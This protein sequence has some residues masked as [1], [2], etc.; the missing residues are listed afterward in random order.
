[1]YAGVRAAG[2]SG[3][4]PTWYR[5]GYGWPYGTKAIPDSVRKVEIRKGSGVD[6][7]RLAR[8]TCGD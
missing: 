6:R 2:G 3:V 5:W 4:F 1:M 7:A 8:K